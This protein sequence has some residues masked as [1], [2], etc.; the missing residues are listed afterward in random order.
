MKSNIKN[1]GNGTLLA[2]SETSHLRN[3]GK[4]MNKNKTKKDSKLSLPSGQGQSAML[5]ERRAALSAGQT[6]SYEELMM[7][8]R[9]SKASNH[10]LDT[11]RNQRKSLHANILAKLQ[12]AGDS[13][14]GRNNQQGGFNRSRQLK[15]KVSKRRLGQSKALPKRATKMSATNMNMNANKTNNNGN[16]G[17]MG[18]TINTGDDSGLNEGFGGGM[19][20]N[21]IDMTTGGLGMTNGTNPNSNNSNNNGNSN[22]GNNN[23]DNM[24]TSFIEAQ[25]E[26]NELEAMVND[27]MQAENTNI[28]IGNLPR[29]CNEATLRQS[30]GHL[31]QIISLRY[32]WRSKNFAFITY[33]TH[34]EAKAAIEDMHNRTLCGNEIKV[35]W[36]RPKGMLHKNNHS[37][38]NSSIHSMNSSMSGNTSELMMSGFSPTRREKSKSA[39]KS[40]SKSNQL[41]V[42]V[43][44]FFFWLFKIVFLL[45]CAFYV[46]VAH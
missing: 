9:K 21:D 35:R 40:I 7:E 30:F 13:N 12:N 41:C 37:S 19:N 6:Q 45:M 27:P 2:H 44:I 11:T 8:S 20:G 24:I 23:G 17:G 26:A 31:G 43:V 42:V 38:E 29:E 36:S 5:R 10:M 28:W 18:L 15:V 34:E 4:D 14:I 3:D 22:N 46:L 1:G 25:Q 39:S 32:D 16:G 33:R